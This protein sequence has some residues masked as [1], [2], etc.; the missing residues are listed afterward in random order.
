MAVL[1]EGEEHA[2]LIS[3]RFRSEM[4]SIRSAEGLQ[5][6]AR[7]VAPADYLWLMSARSGTLEGTMP[8]RSRLAASSSP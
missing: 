3:I 1:G 8:W 4:F 7:P 2:S 6:V 5:R